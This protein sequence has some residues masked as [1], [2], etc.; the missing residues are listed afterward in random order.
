MNEFAADV[1]PQPERCPVFYPLCGID[2]ANLHGLFPNASE[3]FMVA[4]LP[5]GNFSCFMSTFCKTKAMAATVRYFKN[6]MDRFH[7]MAWS[8]T[9]Q[10]LE[11]F[12][13]GRKSITSVDDLTLHDQAVGLLPVLLVTMHLLH[14]REDRPYTEYNT[15]LLDDFEE[16]SHH[17]HSGTS[18]PG[19]SRSNGASNLVKL[20]WGGCKMQLTYLSTWMQASSEPIVLENASRTDEWVTA[21]ES[22]HLVAQMKRISHAVG[23]GERTRVTMFKATDVVRDHLLT[24]NGVAR[25]FM[26]VSAAVVQDPSGLQPFVFAHPIATR[27]TPWELHAYGTFKGK[28]F[29]GNKDTS[30]DEA[31]RLFKLAEGA[32]PALP[33]DY[34]YESL[35]NE[36]K[37]L[38][39]AAWRTGWLHQ[40]PSGHHG[41]HPK[42]H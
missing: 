6:W 36:S 14:F 1:W 20:T 18:T 11:Q 12:N 23:L 25:W 39:M 35:T 30:S 24:D 38:L 33:F 4:A 28:G 3:V 13:A 40:K 29:A 26:D 37:G 15:T 27:S 5:L 10:M 17:L 22:E 9:G 32:G 2:L 8:G 19:A 31:K 34:G 41:G 21:P 7:G 16:H 42:A